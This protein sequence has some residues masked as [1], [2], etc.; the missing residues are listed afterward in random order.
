[1]LYKA[2][3]FSKEK[4]TQASANGD[5]IRLEHFFF[6]YVKSIIE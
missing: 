1:M 2:F 5:P 3:S 4:Y 6:S